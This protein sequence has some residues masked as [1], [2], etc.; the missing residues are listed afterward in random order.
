MSLPSTDGRAAGRPRL[1][2]LM[3][4]AEQITTLLDPAGWDITTSAPER[5]ATDPNGAPI[6][7][8]DA[9]L[10]AVRRTAG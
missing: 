8:T 5:R 10:R 6:T 1:P 3:F 2:H 4:T 7:L 9:V